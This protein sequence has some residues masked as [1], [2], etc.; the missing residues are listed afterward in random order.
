MLTTVRARWRAWSTPWPSATRAR[1]ASKRGHAG[2]RGRTG[3]CC[4]D[5]PSIY[6]FYRSLAPLKPRP[7]W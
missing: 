3:A 4:A 7:A 1:S 2:A 6:G 5:P